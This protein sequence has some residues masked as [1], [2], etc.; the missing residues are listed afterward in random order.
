[1]NFL[2]WLSNYDGFLVGQ[3]GSVVLTAITAVILACLIARRWRA[4]FSK[5]LMPSGGSVTQYR[6]LRSQLRVRKRSD[7][8]PPPTVAK[9]RSIAGAD[10]P[11]LAKRN[12]ISLVNLA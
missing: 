5:C 11:D 7:D 4:R 8:V 1:M 6:C 9:D 3:A 12:L 10:F 2:W